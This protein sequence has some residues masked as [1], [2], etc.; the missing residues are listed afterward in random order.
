[1]VVLLAGVATVFFEVAAQ[2]YLPHVVGRPSLVAANARLGSMDAV[3][4]VAGRSV[5]GYL[6]QVLTAPLAVAVNALTYLWSAFWLLRIDRPEPPPVRRPETHLVREVAEG[7]RFVFGHPLLRPIAIAGALTNFSVQ[8]SVTMLPVV[9]VRELG[10]SP[11][12]LGLYLAGGGLGVFLGTTA[13]RRIG[14]RLGYGRA[15]W[16]IALG[17][18]PLKLLIPLL[19][20]GVMLW[21]AAAAWLLS[22]AQVGINN[23]LQVSLRQRATPDALLGRMNATMRFLLTGALAIGAAVAGLLG[24]HAGTR[25]ALWVGA[26]GLALVW[27]PAFVSPLR[28]LRELP[29]EPA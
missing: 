10:L 2:S 15:M 29:D 3:N 23:V 27:L 19:D 21:V 16:I 4:Q 13:A 20:K 14:R 22:T 12:V 11:G 5:G 17:S 28:N 6:V 9:F 1:V 25:A 7:L 24:E 8:V 18:A 26:I